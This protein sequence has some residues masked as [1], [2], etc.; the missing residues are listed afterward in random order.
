MKKI[1]KKIFPEKH[2][3]KLNWIQTLPYKLGDD[4]KPFPF[5]VQILDRN[6][7]VLERTVVNI[8]GNVLQ[9]WSDD[10]TITSYILT[11]LGLQLDTD[12]S[13]D[14]AIEKLNAGTI[15]YTSG[16]QT[17]NDN[18]LKNYVT[19][20]A[21]Q[22][23]QYK[24]GDI[25]I[26]DFLELEGYSVN[27]SVDSENFTLKNFIKSLVSLANSD[28]TIKLNECITALEIEP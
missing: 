5:E 15:S 22:L 16:D 1:I 24:D 26:D 10:N 28:K 4:N 14:L 12:N 9:N 3:N 17:A 27:I 23:Q 13:T 19:L 2:G 8:P 18:I 21:G 6:N 20:I 25:E 11:A 7:E